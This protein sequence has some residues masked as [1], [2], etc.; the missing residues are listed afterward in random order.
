MID[1]I[2][3][4]LDNIGEWF[5]LLV[6]VCSGVAGLTPTKKDDGI[7]SKIVKVADWF[8]VVNTPANKAILE[9]YA[10]KNK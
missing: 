7:A 3:T 1:W 5:S 10:K 2:L 6:V 8:S 4:H 9:K